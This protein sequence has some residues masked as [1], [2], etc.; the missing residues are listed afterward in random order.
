MARALPFRSLRVLQGDS[1]CTANVSCRYITGRGHRSSTKGGCGT[2]TN[3]LGLCLAAGKYRQTSE[4]SFAHQSGAQRR[5]PL[6]VRGCLLELRYRARPRLPSAV[7]KPAQHDSPHLVGCLVVRRRPHNP[8]RQRLERLVVPPL[9]LGHLGALLVPQLVEGH[10]RAHCPVLRAHRHALL[11]LEEPLCGLHVVPRDAKRCTK[12]EVRIGLV[13]RQGD[14]LAVGPGYF[15]PV[16][17]GVVPRALSQQ[18]RV[19][20]ARLR[21][22]ASLLLCDLAIP[23]LRRPTIL[24]LLPLLPH[25]LVKRPV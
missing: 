15:S 24:H 16:L 14:G 4:L 3:S 21:G 5:S 12:V 11:G 20:V 22:E 1:Q 9:R 19:L 8:H 2:R 18:L 17:L 13:G 6:V 25:L 10:C 7:V 23:L